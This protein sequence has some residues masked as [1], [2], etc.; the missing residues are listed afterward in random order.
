MRAVNGLLP[1]CMLGLAVVAPLSAMAEPA[2][3]PNRTPSERREDPSTRP[4]QPGMV[5]QQLLP[6]LQELDLSD[7]QRQAIRG[8]LED[9]R[10]AFRQRLE[11]LRQQQADP[12]T[13]IE[14]MREL[15]AEVAELISAELNEQQKVIWQK[16]LGEL[17]ERMQQRWR[18][19]GQGP[20][21]RETVAGGGALLGQ[22][23]RLRDAVQA[24]DLT[25]AQRQ[26]FE[27]LLADLR[28][29]LAALRDAGG[30][31]QQIRERVQQLQQHAREKLASILTPEQLQ[32]LQEK[33]RSGEPPRGAP[34]QPGTA[35]AG[36]NDGG[37]PRRP[38][39]EG[40]RGSVEPRPRD[41][42]NP[43]TGPTAPRVPAERS[44]SQPTK[45]DGRGEPSPPAAATTV[46]VVTAQVGQPVPEMTVTRIDGRPMALSSLKGK[47]T[48]LVFGSFSCPSF[49]QRVPHVN[50]AADALGTR[51]NVVYVYTREAH[52][53]GGWEV[54]RNRDEKIRVDAHRSMAERLQQARQTQVAL[55]LEG[56]VLVDDMD[57]RLVRTFDG[58]PNAAVILDRDGVLVRR[59]KWCDPSGWQATLDEALARPAKR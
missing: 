13:R 10:A 32:T 24:L 27:A 52:P 31:P 7:E 41:R 48:I 16:R 30:D 51:V 34:R 18:D 46:P 8:I 39:V 57:D 6:I 15:L 3:D 19:G 23:A 50:A 25:D 56:Q 55:R 9:A 4:G 5:L 49:R 40:G 26:Q 33:M 2:R 54:Q 11:E 29:E 47:P 44:P 42:P 59:Q 14:V 22:F 35:P 17:R 38:F 1:M 28:K 37:G 36:G 53:V 58:F 20:Q 12:R 43:A 21:A 45:P